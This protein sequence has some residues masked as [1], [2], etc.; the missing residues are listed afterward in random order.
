MFGT[1]P[2]EWVL[3]MQVSEKTGEIFP[4][5]QYHP[6]G[7]TPRIDPDLHFDQQPIL[8]FGSNTAGR[9]G[10][11]AAKLAVQLF[12]AVEG[13]YRGR[14]GQS[15]AIPTRRRLEN[16]QIVSLTLEEII[17]GI[18]EFVEYTR[19]NP[20]L[21]FFVM[22]V[23]TGRAGFTPEQIAPHFRSAISCSFPES[24]RDTLDMTDQA[25]IDAN[26]L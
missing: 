17:P 7:D 24:W 26:P 3:M 1:A 18:A 20:Q 13:Y 23:G 10:A 4:V 5:R 21:S 15:Y 2:P 25:I 6:D 12:G 9:H 14:M 11:G 8:V 16:K 22:G 19:D